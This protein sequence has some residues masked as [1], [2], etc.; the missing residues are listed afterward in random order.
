MREPSNTTFAQHNAMRRYMI[1][2]GNHLSDQCI[3]IS[4]WQN[5]RN[6]S[7]CEEPSYFTEPYSPSYPPSTYDLH[8]EPEPSEE[9]QMI[10]MLKDWLEEK[11]AQID[12][13]FQRQAESIQRMI[14]QVR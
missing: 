9:D 13:Q 11:E 8:Q 14:D 5:Y 6:Q 1:C 10:Y 2:D 4:E 7:Q 3:Y 12:A